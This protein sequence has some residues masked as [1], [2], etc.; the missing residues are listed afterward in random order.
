MPVPSSPNQIQSIH[1]MIVMGPGESWKSTE[2]LPME[3][4]FRATRKPPKHHTAMR[5]R[6][7]KSF[8]MARR[9]M[10]SMFSGIRLKARRGKRMGA[11]MAR[12]SRAWWPREGSWRRKPWMRMM[13]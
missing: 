11:A 13:R 3:S 6:A 7:T 9:E 5:D 2:D 12:M 10:K 4:H 8:I 1:F